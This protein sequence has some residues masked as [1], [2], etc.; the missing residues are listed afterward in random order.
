MTSRDKDIYELGEAAGHARL[1]AT[2][3]G[4]VAKQLGALREMSDIEE[5]TD[6]AEGQMFAYGHVMNMID[7]SSNE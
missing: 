7:G 1:L 5:M 4:K 3:R 6:Y 2:M